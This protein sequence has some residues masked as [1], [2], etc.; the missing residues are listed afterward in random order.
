MRQNNL[1]N[2]CFNCCYLIS[3]S[4]VLI[5]AFQIIIFLHFARVMT[6]LKHKS[7]HVIALK[8]DFSKGPELLMMKPR[9][10]SGLQGS[11]HTWYL[12]HPQSC[13]FLEHTLLSLLQARLILF[14]CLSQPYLTPWGQCDF[15]LYM[16]ILL[17]PFLALC[18]TNTKHPNV[19]KVCIS[20]KA[21]ILKL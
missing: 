2:S 20:A 9:S 1:C 11:S 17:T 16:I 5:S 15:S 18:L 8:I 12:S 19:L 13:A 10:S 4:S 3:L 21:V 6:F 14:T 7:D